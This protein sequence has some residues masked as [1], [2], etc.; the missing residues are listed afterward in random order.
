[1]SKNYR[2]EENAVR[3]QRLRKEAKAVADRIYEAR[4]NSEMTQAV[5]ADFAGVSVS[6]VKRYEHAEEEMS[7]QN[8]FR[9]ASALNL[10]LADIVSENKYILYKFSFLSAQDQNMIRAMI[11]K[12]YVASMVQN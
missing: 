2:T 4:K 3:E 1:M 8:L 11:D 9:I 12:C 7:I 5:L 6:T 10:D